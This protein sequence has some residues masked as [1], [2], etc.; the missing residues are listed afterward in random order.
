MA[1]PFNANEL[2]E[3]LRGLDQRGIAYEVEYRRATDIVDGM[4][5]RI[6]FG[7]QVWEV[8]FYENNLIEVLRFTLA[9]DVEAGVTAASLLADLDVETQEER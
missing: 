1:E 5:V 4:A 2:I 7:S 8:G 6:L 3:L 9:G